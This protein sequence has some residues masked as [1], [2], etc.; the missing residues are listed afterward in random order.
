[1]YI[2]IYI[3]IL[4]YHIT[5][6]VSVVSVCVCVFWWW[7]PTMYVLYRNL[8]PFGNCVPAAQAYSAPSSQPT[9]IA[10][11]SESSS[12]TLGSIV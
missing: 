3:Y 12:K 11:P 10:G 1:M 7:G 2:H 9:M 4:S 6:L 8:N 5:F